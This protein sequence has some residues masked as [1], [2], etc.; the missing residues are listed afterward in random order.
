M[1]TETKED[2]TN[3]SYNRSITRVTQN[4]FVTF[5]VL[6]CSGA[7]VAL[8]E[9]P[10]VTSI[11]TYEVRI[12]TTPSGGG[13][14]IR[15][16]VRGD[17]KNADDALGLVS[18][19]EYRSFWVSWRDGNIKFGKGLFPGTGTLLVWKDPSPHDVS[20]IAVTTLSPNV[21]LWSFSNIHGQY[22]Y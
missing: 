12:G 10:G 2:I 19:T 15:D 6:A 18:C 14:E 3:Y 17:V 7:F 16:S 8:S 1:K 4:D 22:L 20:S 9:F 5:N 13:V 11:S 21:G